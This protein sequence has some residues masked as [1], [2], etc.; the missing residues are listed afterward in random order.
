MV[1]NRLG[2]TQLGDTGSF[3]TA[4][5]VAALALWASGSPSI[6]Y[7][8]Y[9]SDWNLTASLVTIVFAAY[10]ISLVVTLLVFGSLSDY[11]GRRA[12]L[13]IGV[14]LIAG[15]ILLFAVAPDVV[16]LLLGRVLQGAGVGFAMGAAS[17]AMVEYNRGGNPGRASSVNTA[18]TALGLALATIVGGALVEYAPFPLHLSYWVLF[19][20]AGI[21]FGAV[22]LMP[23]GVVEGGSGPGPGPAS[24]GADAPAVARR[25]RPQ[26]VAVPRGLR[27]VFTVSALAISAGYAMGALLLSLGSQI[28]KDLI[29]TDNALVAGVALSISAIVIGVVA[30]LAR[31]LAPRTSITVGGFSIA[32]GLG[33]L[34][35]SAALESL[36]VFIA[37][38]VVAGAGYGWLF[39]GGL[40]LISR[41]AP[42]QHRAS[43]LSAVYLVAYLAQ[44][45]IAVL[46]G[47]SATAFGLEPALDLWAPAIAAIGL[48]ASASA[49]ASSVGVRRRQAEA[50]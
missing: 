12:T 25:W 8:V 7:P 33:L 3:F 18:A 48:A 9:T 42:A 47:Q 13:L 41:H 38:S 37:A 2:R 6:V 49:I 17:A 5:S 45:V 16:W 24:P 22:W 36:P 32:L 11:I 23:R 1:R 27:V 26:R 29:K 4:A 50:G 40:G 10:P 43:T 28:A 44:G 35:L 21:V 30:I 19:G 39:L 31:S 34:E 20:I 46:I 14:G 15:G